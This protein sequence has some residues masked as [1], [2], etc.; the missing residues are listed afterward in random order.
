MGVAL[1]SCCG[2]SSGVD[3]RGGALQTPQP[4]AQEEPL[5]FTHECKSVTFC[6]VRGWSLGATQS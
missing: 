1:G 3:V 2:K 6:E 5:S 4:M